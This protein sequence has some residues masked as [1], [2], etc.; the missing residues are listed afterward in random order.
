VG[1]RAVLDVIPFKRSVN[2]L[3]AEQSSTIAVTK[4]LRLLAAAGLSDI[5]DV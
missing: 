2:L 1:L 5:S 3:S 4:S